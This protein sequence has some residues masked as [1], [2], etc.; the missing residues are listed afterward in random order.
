[1]PMRPFRCER[2][3][4]TEVIY[5]FLYGVYMIFCYLSITVTRVVLTTS[6]ELVKCTYFGKK[7]DYSTLVS[8]CVMIYMTN[9]YKKEKDEPKLLCPCLREH[10]FANIVKIVDLLCG[11]LA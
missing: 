5:F 10:I 9:T 3:Q 6:G 11:Y 1:M 2:A 4:M 8:D 7:L